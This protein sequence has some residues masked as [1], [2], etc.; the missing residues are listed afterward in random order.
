VT[1]RTDRRSFLLGAIAVLAPL[2]SI[3]CG[4]SSGN[5]ESDSTPVTPQATT[6]PATQYF[7]EASV[8]SA[9][10][11][12]A[13]Y[14]AVAGA[15]IDSLLAPVR[16]MID[17]ASSDDAAITALRAQVTSDFKSGATVALDGWVCARTELAL[18]ALIVRSG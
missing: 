13:R 6:S 5:D 11:I 16:S 7:A 12:G 8:D 10:V 15:E 1:L 17:G 4:S 18:C 3:G 14:I 9:R 2:P